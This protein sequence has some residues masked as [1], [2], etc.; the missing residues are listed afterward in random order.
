MVLFTLPGDGKRATA[1]M[2]K[3]LVWN[4]T[5]LVTPT[6]RFTHRSAEQSSTKQWNDAELA[7][8]R[9][10]QKSVLFC[11]FFYFCIFL[12]GLTFLIGLV[13]LVV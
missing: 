9:R 12:V 8:C 13:V 6:R 1:D 4:L 3:A 5:W 10:H 11:C 7:D 2:N